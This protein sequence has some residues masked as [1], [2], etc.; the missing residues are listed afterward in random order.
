M[1]FLVLSKSGYYCGMSM[2]AAELHKKRLKSTG[3]II[4][5]CNVVD[6]IRCIKM[7]GNRILDQK[8]SIGKIMWWP[9]KVV[10]IDYQE[11]LQFTSYS[12]GENIVIGNGVE[13]GRF[14]VLNGKPVKGEEFSNLLRKCR[15][16]SFY[17]FQEK[18]VVELKV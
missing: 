10:I 14:R 2:N 11:N 13:I 6:V 9:T 18:A 12:D 8:V 16:L 3:S 1:L 15:G 5:C 4:K 7:S 17:N